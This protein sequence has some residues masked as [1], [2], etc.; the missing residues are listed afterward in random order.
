MFKIGIIGCGNLGRTHATCIAELEGMASSA[1]CD[2]Y[3]PNALQLLETFGGDYATSD[4]EQLFADPELDAIYVTTQ[5]DTHA[6]YCIR[7]LDAG[8]HVLVEKPLAMTLEQCLA[9]GEAVNRSGRMLFTAFK[10]RYYELLWKAKEL[11]PQPVTITMQMMDDRWGNG[12]WPNDPVKGGG[13]VISQ[14]CHSADIMRFVAGGDPV[15]VY[16]AGGNYYQPSGVIDNL[17]AVFRFDN[18]AAG[19]LVQGD[20]NCPPLASK[21]FMQLFAE[22]KS[23]TLSDRLTTLTYSEA[24]KE[25]QIFTGTESGFME[26]NKAFLRC[27]QENGKATI[28]HVDGLYATLMVLQAIASLGSGKPEPIQAYVERALASSAEPGSGR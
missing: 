16:A 4:P 8:K 23:V 1:Y 22:G 13:N 17:V 6:E 15:E 7:A 27:L 24:G 10:M 21:F 11:I 9:I 14:G 28:D 20:C 18:G 26:E 3:E 5:H 2:V 12:I 19:S 25:P